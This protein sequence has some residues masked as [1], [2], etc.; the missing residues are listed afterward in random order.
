MKRLRILLWMLVSL[1]A[2]SGLVRADSKTVEL[3]VRVEGAAGTVIVEDAAGKE[4][5]R[6]RVEAGQEH[7]FQLK[8]ASLAECRY[9]IRQIGHAAKVQYDTRVYDVMVCSYLDD[10]EK[11]VNVAV[12][13]CEGKKTE[14]LV[15]RNQT[16]DAPIPETGDRSRTWVYL[17]MMAVSAAGIWIA[18]ARRQKIR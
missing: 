14:K 18:I 17:I 7:L 11:E 5:E 12:I 3:P 13:S 1:A 8:T 16:K 4:I 9:R 6:V 10:E 15:F 2:G